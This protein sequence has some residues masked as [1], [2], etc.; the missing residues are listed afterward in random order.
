MAA[1]ESAWE[2]AWELAWKLGRKCAFSLPISAGSL[3]YENRRPINR[4]PLQTRH[5]DLRPASRIAAE[6]PAPA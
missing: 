6:R 3:V 2:L 1:W 4:W 5:H